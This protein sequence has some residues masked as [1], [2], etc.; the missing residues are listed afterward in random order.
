[1]PATFHD[2]VVVDEEFVEAAHSAG[3]AV[4]VWTINDRD[5]MEQLCDIGVDGIISDE[6]SVL[7]EVLN[8]R[9]IAWRP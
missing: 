9:G 7:V 3:L 8:T 6:P 2:L 5:E 1:V 4:H